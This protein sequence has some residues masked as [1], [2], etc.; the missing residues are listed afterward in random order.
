MR[1]DTSISA[2]PSSCGCADAAGGHSVAQRA[3]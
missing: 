3:A 2:I 1:H